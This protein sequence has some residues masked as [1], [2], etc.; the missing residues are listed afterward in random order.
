[1]LS[2]STKYLIIDTSY[3]MYRSYFAYPNLSNQGAMVGAIYGFCKTVLT[4][5]EKYQINE[6]IFAI[7]LPEKTL[8]HQ[9]YEGYKAGRKPIEETMLLQ[10][11][12]ILQWCQN[13]TPNYFGISGYEADDVVFS[14][15]L[16]ILTDSKN[17]I[18]DYNLSHIFDDNKNN[19]NNNEI[20]ILSSDKDLYQLLIFEQVKILKSQN[21][22]LTIY[23]S[24]DFE[25]EFNL[26]PLQ[27]LDYKTLVGD[28]SDNLKGISGIGPKT[29]TDFLKHYGSLVEF[30]RIQNIEIDLKNK[31]FYEGYE[32]QEIEKYQNNNKNQQIIK[33]IIEQ[34][35]ELISTYN[36]VSLFYINN[37]EIKSGIF[38]EKGLETFK[39]Y[40]FKSLIDLVAKKVQ[41]NSI[42]INKDENSL[43]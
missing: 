35:D 17:H 19:I 18:S 6:L 3:L 4:I 26:H 2:N 33:K 1:M 8:R 28:S 22:Q 25:K 23:T 38:L 30:F 24:K 37:L 31:S 11:P 34:K 7:D 40:N 13:I 14:T 27:W 20:Y 39:L 10:I 9:K 16:K 29:A 32:F 15:V 12:S 36:L 43:F 5:L 21:K 41:S 42:N